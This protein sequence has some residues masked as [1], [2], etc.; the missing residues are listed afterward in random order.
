MSLVNGTH[1]EILLQ[2]SQND[3]TLLDCD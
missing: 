1:K 2:R 3:K